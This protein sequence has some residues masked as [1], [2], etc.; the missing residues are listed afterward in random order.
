MKRKASTG[1]IF[2]A[3]FL[4]LLGFGMVLPL[5]PLYATDPRFA[6]SPAEI[7]WLM[8]IYSIMQFVCAP[9][10]GRLSDR[11]GR[12]PTLILG[13][14]GSALSYLA[15]GL[16]NTLW[17]LFMARAVAG[18]MGANIAVAQAAMADLSPVEDRSKAM[19]L[20]G[21]AFGLGFI[22]GPAFG[23][24]L[25]G[26]GIEAAPLVAALVTGLNA[27]AAL[28]YLPETRPAPLPTADTTPT[29][30]IRP[31]HPLLSATPW[32]MARAFPGAWVACQVVG[33]FVTLFSA[34]EVVL[35]LWG[36]EFMGWNM[37]HTGWIFTFVGVVAVLTQGGLVR[38]LLPKIGEKRVASGG[39]LLVSV[40]LF[41]LDPNS[42]TGMLVA[43]ALIALGSGL[44]HPA[45]SGLASLNTDPATQ[46]AMLG[47]YQSM[48]ALGRSIGPVLGGSIY[49]TARGGIFPLTA[50]GIAGVLLLF[51]L[52]GHR[53]RDLRSPPA[54][55]PDAP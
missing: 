30:R 43:L 14:A 22:L 4:D 28:F 24:W 44:L 40:G 25:A 8:A 17:V 10:W 37:T 53:M 2:T 35:P 26:F 27:L 32:T 11:V 39:L 21:A 5:M 47:L 41:A 29:A 34:F 18:M 3:V 15:Y 48:S 36:R 13:L 19:G 51:V 20:I 33:L 1:V 23:G 38:R 6:A 52:Q 49:D 46:G 55:S 54:P 12:R 42:W 7:G 16:A 9:Y 50:M 45:L 31:A